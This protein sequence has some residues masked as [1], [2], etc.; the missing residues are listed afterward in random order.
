MALKSLIDDLPKKISVVR[1]S[2]LGVIIFLRRD[3][4]RYIIVQNLAQFENLYQAYDLSWDSE[5]FLRLVFWLC[6]AAQ[7]IGASR[8]T[9]ENLNREDILEH[10]EQLW[11]KKL[12]TDAAKEAYTAQWVFAALTDFNGRLQAR[13]I[14]RFLYHAAEITGLKQISPPN[15]AKS[16]F[17]CGKNVPIGVEPQDKSIR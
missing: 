13:D 7:I 17:M 2:N 11:G 5:S 15:Q 3:Y 1:Q 12:G 16:C 14:V 8:E 4:L 9:I 6:S 10:L